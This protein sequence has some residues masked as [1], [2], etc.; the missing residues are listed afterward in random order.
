LRYRKKQ[1]YLEHFNDIFKTAVA[2]RLRAP[3]IVISLSGGLDS[4]AIAATVRDI[5]ADGQHPSELNAV[6]VLY[7]SIHASDEKHYA[8]LVSQH[9][10]LPTHYIDGGKYPFMSPPVQTSR[11][12]E[13]YQPALW[14]DM[15]NK[16]SG[17]GRVMLTGEAGDNLLHFSSVMSSLKDI[18]LF[19]LPSTIYQLKALYGT[20]PP[21]GTGLK[22]K[23]NRLTGK[24]TSASTIPYP[25]W[26]N[27]ELEAR[28]GLKQ[29]WSEWHHWRP[30]A[31]YPRYSTL[32]ETMLRPDWNT[33]DNYMHTA[34]TEPE[35]RDPFL[36][37]RLVK[38]V[39]SLPALPWL[40]N[41]HLLRTALHGFLPEE[42]IKRRKTALGNIHTTLV[43]QPGSNWSN[44]WQAI[45]EL[46]RFVVRKKIP[47]FDEQFN[48]S[49]K[50]YMSLRPYLLNSW[51]QGL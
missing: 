16:A 19:N 44:D 13:L 22:A 30:P 32:Y 15:A 10:K 45:P 1:E 29:R 40:F 47:V 28:L 25:A 2:D 27:P 3:R 38:F 31:T 41:K 49:M 11:P 42:V 48:D 18:N 14:L 46:D 9:L 12:M 39:A 34:F 23:L 50:A 43:N 51:I 24:K 5:Q 35:N 8:K 33:D 36:D 20:Y 21:F 26:L 37:L 7:D 4:S 6:T 17:F